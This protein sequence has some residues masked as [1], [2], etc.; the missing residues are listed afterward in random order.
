MK[1]IFFIFHFSFFILGAAYAAPS[2][3]AAIQK[4]ISQAQAQQKQVEQKVAISSREVEK[5]KKQLVGAAEKVS[6]LEEQRGAMTKKIAELDAQRTRLTASLAQN[7]A[8]IADSAAGILFIASNPSFDS[9]NMRDYVLTSALL[10]GAA[11]QFDD[12]IADAAAKIEELGQI[13]DARA[14]EK[15]KLDRTAKK[16]AAEKKDLDKL[17]ATRAAQNEKLQ[18][19]QD[20][21]QK[22]LRDLSARAKN[23]SELTAGV[24]ATEMSADA[25][26]SRRKLNA[27]VR[28]RLTVMFGEKSALGLVS[29]GWRIRARG[30]AL[31]VAPADGIVKFADNFK[32]FGRVLILSHANGYNTVMTNLGQLDAVLGQEVLAGEPVGRMNPEKPE[33]YL[34]VRR[35][36]NAIDPARLFNEP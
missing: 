10:S 25:R 12:E 21:L 15:E 24:G 1:K 33:M 22:K 30:D 23:I 11:K 36:K 35:G 17:L 32:G 31:V 28:G 16:Y 8:R 2:E 6:D 20:D 26:F 13:I 18:R 4:Q 5:T 14:V 9:E 34:E 19:Q 29:D 27:P 3:L 7:R